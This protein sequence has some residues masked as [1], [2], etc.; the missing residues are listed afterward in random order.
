MFLDLTTNAHQPL[1]GTVCAIL[2]LRKVGLETYDFVLLFAPHEIDP[3]L[4]LGLHAG[5]ASVSLN[6]DAFDAAIG[7]SFGLVDSACC[8]S[9]LPL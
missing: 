4:C 5:H 8:L 7:L 3:V 1:L 2:R 9:Q 6:F